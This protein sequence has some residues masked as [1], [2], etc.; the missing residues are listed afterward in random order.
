MTKTESKIMARGTSFKH[1]ANSPA[2]WTL[3]ANACSSSNVKLLNA[4]LKRA[5]LRPAA[6]LMVGS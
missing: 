5:T 3:R 1:D 4:W 2:I 6:R